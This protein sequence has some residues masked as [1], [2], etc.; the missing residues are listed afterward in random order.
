VVIGLIVILVGLLVP[1]LARGQ[2]QSREL[3]LLA[4]VRRY[5]NGITIVAQDNG[6]FTTPYIQEDSRVTGQ[7]DVAMILAYRVLV[8]EGIYKN[9]LEVDRV[10]NDTVNALTLMAVA[11][12]FAPPGEFKVN[13]TSHYKTIQAR[14]VQLAI[15]RNPSM[16]G[17][18]Y[19]YQTGPEIGHTWCCVSLWNRG[20]VAFMDGHA[21]LRA[22][23][24]F[25]WP[26]GVTQSQIGIPV[27][28]TLDGLRG[29]DRI[30]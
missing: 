22:A 25:E 18:V 27:V 7:L 23:G 30:R 24:E 15:A 9:G 11:G 8:R 5:M 6:G 26:E 19:Q 10:G 12:L 29:A 16:K 1:V 14:P 2:A 28:T 3:V 21:S 4:D 13:A 20:A 17:G